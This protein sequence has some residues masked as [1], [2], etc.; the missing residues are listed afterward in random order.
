MTRAPAM[1]SWRQSDHDIGKHAQREQEETDPQHDPRPHPRCGITGQSASD[2]S[3][4]REEHEDEQ[5]HEC[6]LA[7]ERQQCLIYLAVR[8][9]NDEE[10]EVAGETEGRELKTIVIGVEPMS[11]KERLLQSP[12]G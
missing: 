5:Q 9:I 6:W 10:K 2:T 11:R 4:R 1:E 3:P 8:P 12:E 7:K